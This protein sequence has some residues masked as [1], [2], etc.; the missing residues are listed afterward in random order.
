MPE[1]TTLWCQRL[2][3]GIKGHVVLRRCQFV[4]GNAGIVFLALV[5]ARGVGLYV[6]V[7]VVQFVF[8]AGVRLSQKKR[9]SPGAFNFTVWKVC[10]KTTILPKAGGKLPDGNS[11]RVSRTR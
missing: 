5:P 8:D 1:C 9:S 6:S 2:S 3:V 11:N 7:C 4:G 10:N